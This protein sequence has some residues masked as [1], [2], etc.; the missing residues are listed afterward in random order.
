MDAWTAR[1]GEQSGDA[2]S[3][4]AAWTRVAEDPGKC[5]KSGDDRILRAEALAHLAE[6]RGKAGDRVGVEAALAQFSVLW[7]TPDPD[8]EVSKRVA[9]VRAGFAGK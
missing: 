3:A 9:A 4:L 5:G 2:A 7:P 8:L 1:I 6:A